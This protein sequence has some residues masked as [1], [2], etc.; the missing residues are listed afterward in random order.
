MRTLPVLLCALLIVP[1]A[2]NAQIVNG[3]FEDG[4]NGWTF[5]YPDGGPPFGWQDGGSG[6]VT[7]TLCPGNVAQLVTLDAAIPALGCLSQEFTCG[8]SGGQCSISMDYSFDFQ[9]VTATLLVRIDGNPVFSTNTAVAS[10]TTA[11]PFLLSSGTHTV[12]LC[13]DLVENDFGFARATFDN[14]VADCNSPLPTRRATWGAIKA[15]FE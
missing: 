4:L 5:G 3:D 2:T 7:G 13:L 15:L 11:G 1:F 8:P 10:C 14:V 12:E 9:N 6:V